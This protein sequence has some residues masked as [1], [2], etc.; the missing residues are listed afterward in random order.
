MTLQVFMYKVKNRLFRTFYTLFNLHP[1]SAPYISPDGFWRLA[2]HRLDTGRNMDGA[3][4]SPGDVVFVRTDELER[5]RKEVLPIIHARFVLITHDSDV[6][7]D[8][9]KVGIADDPRIIHW[10]AKNLLVR[11]PKVTAIPI[12][13]EN[14]RLHNNGIVAH[15]DRLRANSHER[16]IRIL[17]AFA[18]GT[19]KKSRGAALEVLRS[20][21]LA[22]GPE[23]V[24]SKLYREALVEYAFVVSPQGN[25]FDCHRTWEALY[26]GTIPIVERSPFFDSFPDLPVLAVDDWKVMSSWDE[27][28]LK[29]T[30]EE[31]SARLPSC[32]YLWLDYWVRQIAEQRA[33]AL[34]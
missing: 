17:Y 34:V 33:K 11:H 10:F 26:V 20:M 32:P 23:W 24:H 14:R 15:F 27:A 18:V 1:T 22:D 5:F 8:E 13:L 29:K 30:Y 7:I 2:Q 16:K 6:N 31:L 9:S 4:V 28:F 12:G 19:N 25:G 21:P 3:R